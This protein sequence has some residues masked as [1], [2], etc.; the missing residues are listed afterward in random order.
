MNQSPP[1]APALVYRRGYR[2]RVYHLAPAHPFQE[3]P[4][5]AL[6]GFTPGFMWYGTYDHAEVKTGWP[7]PRY[8][9]ECDLRRREGER[10]GLERANHHLPDQG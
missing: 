3:D 8:C 2:G 10:D 6:C 4:R 5:P 7:R 9:G 1:P